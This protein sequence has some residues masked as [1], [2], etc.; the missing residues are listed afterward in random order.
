MGEEMTFGQ[1]RGEGIFEKLDPAIVTNL[2]NIVPEARMGEEGVGVSMQSDRLLLPHR[3]VPE[4]R[5]GA[6]VVVE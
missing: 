3:R 6:A 1:G 5:L 4:E 2:A